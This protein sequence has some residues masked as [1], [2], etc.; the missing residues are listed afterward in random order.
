[1]PKTRR[2]RLGA[3]V[4]AMRPASLDILAPP[5]RAEDPG[6]TGRTL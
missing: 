6:N 5:F 4:Y 3:R 1:M 2:L